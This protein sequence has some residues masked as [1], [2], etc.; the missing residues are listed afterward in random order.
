MNKAKEKSAKWVKR[1]RAE[2]DK[3]SEV[4][5]K[6]A[7]P[8]QFR[9]Y[10]NNYLSV[11]NNTMWNAKLDKKWARQQFEIYVNKQ[12]VLDGFFSSIYNRW[13]KEANNSIW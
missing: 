8:T 1:N 5:P 13:R 12:K 10:L 11:Y 9:I 4:S 3:F 6:T 7:N 2:W